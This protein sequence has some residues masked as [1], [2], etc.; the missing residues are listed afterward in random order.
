[1]LKIETGC[2]WL[3]VENFYCF[4]HKLKNLRQMEAMA[5]GIKPGNI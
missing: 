2:N 1:V 5:T 4:G 3:E